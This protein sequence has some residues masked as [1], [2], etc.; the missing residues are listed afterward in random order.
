MAGLIFG[1]IF[2]LVGVGLGVFFFVHKETSYEEDFY[3]Y[4]KDANGHH[5]QRTTH[6]FKKFALLTMIAGILLAM[7]LTLLGCIASVPTGHTGVVT[8]FG[9]VEDTTFDAGFHM[10]AP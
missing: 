2:L 9:K 7:L 3:G 4:K 8:T 10:K 6:P 5:I 1:I